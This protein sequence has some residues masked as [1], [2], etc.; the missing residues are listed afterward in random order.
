[1]TLDLDPS[2]R[3]RLLAGDG[4]AWDA[5][6]AWM[7]AAPEARA[8]AEALAEIEALL[9]GWPAEARAAEPE[10]W[11]DIS[12]G[13]EPPAWWPLVQTVTLGEFATL[14]PVAALRRVLA[15]RF[16]QRAHGVQLGPL[17]DLPGLR[18]L[19]LGALGGGANPLPAMPGLAGL[20]G[21]ADALP[22]DFAHRFSGL[23]SLS[24]AH[25]GRLT[26]LPPLPPGLASLDLSGCGALTSIAAVAA[27][28]ELRFIDLRGCDAL[29][30]LEP[31]AALPAVSQ[32]W[33][34]ARRARA[35]DPL[36]G[37]ASLT[38][39]LL[40]GG[41][42]PVDLNP[43]AGHPGLR[44]LQ[45]E[46]C[47]AVAGLEGLAL[48][49]LEALHVLRCAVSG[50]PDLTAAPRLKVLDLEG[51]VALRALPALAPGATLDL[52]RLC[53]LPGLEANAPRPPARR[54]VV[55]GI[56]Q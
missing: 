9:A 1:M 33:I 4:S 55:D 23:T 25:S 56:A 36:A 10:A 27:C 3:E 49:A 16:G 31:L 30:G 2:L 52:L 6:R 17:S 18:D 37:R 14:E 46:G 29:E 22:E 51:L 15:L 28:P 8:G 47:D 26:R 32:V 54:V 21:V 12:A 42:A 45:L 20:S 44:T 53:D 34:D 5:L 24:L 50:L 39:L 43:L 19:S 11:S 7:A 40:A 13:G 48:P 35:L 38:D 41:G